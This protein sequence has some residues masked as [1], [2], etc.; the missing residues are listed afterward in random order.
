MYSAGPLLEK[1]K[2][3]L[4]HQVVAS[5]LHLRAIESANNLPHLQHMSAKPAVQ[6]EFDEKRL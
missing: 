2:I 6:H 1:A 5:L 3:S 4:T